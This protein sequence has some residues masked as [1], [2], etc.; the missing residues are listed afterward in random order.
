MVA[1]G[2]LVVI[3]VLGVKLKLELELELELLLMSTRRIKATGGPQPWPSH[4]RS[5]SA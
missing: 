1:L 2:G 5:P 4:T 3:L